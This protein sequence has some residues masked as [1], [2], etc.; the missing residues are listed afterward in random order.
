[1]VKANLST[2][3][4]IIFDS[5]QNQDYRADEEKF[6]QAKL[7]NLDPITE[8]QLRD[9]ATKYPITEEFGKFL[10]G[11]NFQ[12]VN[13]DQFNKVVETHFDNLKVQYGFPDEVLN[14]NNYLKCYK[15]CLLTAEM[16]ENNNTGTE[17]AS[18]AFVMHLLFDGDLKAAETA[19]N[20]NYQV[21]NPV[22][23]ALMHGIPKYQEGAIKLDVAGWRALVK[24][25]GISAKD[26]IENFVSAIELQPNEKAAES[27]KEFKDAQEVL[28]KKSFVRAEENIELAKLCKLY[29]VDEKIFNKCLDLMKDVII[30]DKTADAIPDIIVD[31]G[32]I[33]GLKEKDGY[34]LVK[35][36]SGDLRAM[37]LG[38]ITDC[39]QSIGGHSE[40]CVIDGITRE[41]NGFYVLLKGKKGFN[42]KKID[43]ENLE[44]YAKI[45]GQGYV[46]RSQSDA[47]LTFDSWENLKNES[48]DQMMFKVLQQFGKQVSEGLYGVER[49]TIGIGGKT[50]EYIKKMTTCYVDAMKEGYNY[51]DSETQVEVFVSNRLE[52]VRKKLAEKTKVDDQSSIISVEHGGQVS[53]L[54]DKEDIFSGKLKSYY[55]FYSGFRV[56]EFAK[57]FSLG[58][59]FF[60]Q[61]DVHEIRVLLSSDARQVYKECNL[62]PDDFNG[63]GANKIKELTS[64]SARQV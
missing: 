2:S 10:F 20:G 32:K 44:E 4:S 63:V 60:G 5:F 62:K 33:E 23:D 40:E 53:S 64:S 9:F 52:E 54:L 48:N 56:V 27:K 21:Q 8:D 24:M 13:N 37:I 50:P 51:G 59:E 57:T 19:I 36:P 55:S 26:V 35:L 39:C 49:V 45:E 6:K 61:Q 7:N 31:I 22:H 25:K 46:W 3:Y 38:E 41:N 15:A 14:F 1:M 30:H 43:W 16:I 18:R 29:K 11:E 47:T 42:Q 58:D 12:P 17:V 28:L 34:Y